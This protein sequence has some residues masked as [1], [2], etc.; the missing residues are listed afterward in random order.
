MI[1][2]T[3][4]E[5]AAVDDAELDLL[6]AALLLGALDHPGVRLV[7]YRAHLDQIADETA[8]IAQN[9]DAPVT[10]AEALSQ[11]IA[12]D[13]GYAGDREA[14]DDPAN[15]NLIDMIDRRKGL[16]VTLS[17]LYLGIARRLEWSA[18]GIN[19]PGHFLLR[20]GDDKNHVIQD[21]FTD[22]RLIP[23]GHTIAGF[24]TSDVPQIDVSNILSD[25]GVLVR[26]LNNVAARAEKS[27]DLDRA[28]V[29][30]GRMTG[31]APHFTLLWWERAKLEKRM[32]H[33]T[34]ARSSLISLLETT[35]DADMISKAR[36]QLDSLTRSVN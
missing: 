13:H 11:C 28:L 19:H 4:A 21:P 27:G 2:D 29:M 24:D 36:G 17:V 23:L 22:G 9:S 20:I 10:Q 32:G 18:A 5:L 34:A 7:P 33:L 3:L 12:F 35:R 16:P 14:Y 1:M 6:E 26:L 8:L 15:A 30:H 31:I 25:R